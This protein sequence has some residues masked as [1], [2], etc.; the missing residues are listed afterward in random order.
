MAISRVRFGP[1]VE[2]LRRC[3]SYASAFLRLALMYI[4][5]ALQVLA[6]KFDRGRPSMIDKGY[7]QL[8][9]YPFSSD[10]KRMSVIYRSPQNHD[11]TAPCI[12]LMKGAVERVLDA[13]AYIRTRD[14]VREIKGADQDQ[15]MRNVDTMAEQGLR[16]LALAG[17][18]WSGI[19]EDVDRAEVEQDMTFFGLVGIYDP[20]R[21]CA[22][23]SLPT[24][25]TTFPV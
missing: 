19:A 7:E 16:V 24:P 4:R 17:R 13:C 3:T 1:L 14:G 6:H 23:Q 21:K 25:L 11:G 10:L 12:A 20:P 9:E 18:D 15:I 8:A 22:P 5:S 2:T